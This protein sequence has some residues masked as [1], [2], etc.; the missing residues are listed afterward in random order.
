MQR[1]LIAFFLTCFTFVPASQAQLWHALPPIS[2]TIG[3]PQAQFSNDEKKVFYLNGDGKVENIWS[4]VVA[5][6]YGRIIAGPKNPPVQI[7]K[8]TDRGVARFFHLL[9]SSDILYMRAT[10]NGK[11]YHIY[12]IADDGSGAPQDITP[13]PDGV[14]NIIL[15]AS[16]NGRYVYYTSNKVNRDKTDVYRYDTQQYTSEDV[17]PNDKDYVAL[18]WS[19]D[20]TKLLMER[21]STG[22]LSLYDMETTER[23]LITPPNNYPI[24]EAI[25]DPISQDII[26]LQQQH[27]MADA[28]MLAFERP[29]N[30]GEWKSYKNNGDRIE[31]SPSGKYE[32]A[33][34]Y[35]M[36]DWSVHERSSGTELPLPPRTY[37]LAF[38]PKET[39]LLYSRSINDGDNSLLYLYD[40]SKGSTTELPTMR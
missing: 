38:S 9:G 34:G 35:G 7:T 2:A 5:D 8:F 13:G 40:I 21:P 39:M 6:K 17:F 10:D 29:L 22:E 36:G 28:M 30:S 26:I 12:R 14:T 4:V 1:F 20:Q 37:P 31:F 24:G 11:D 16:Y 3:Q 23:D 25:L 33:F 18:A 27:K 19:R 15:G 32:I